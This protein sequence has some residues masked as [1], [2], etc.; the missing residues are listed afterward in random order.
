MADEQ[1]AI[2]TIL[3]APK[4]SRIRAARLLL[5]AI[6]LAPELV[7]L[8]VPAS[9]Q[10][11]ERAAAGGPAAPAEAATPKPAARREPGRVSLTASE[12]ESDS[13]G[14]TE[15]PE[16]EPASGSAGRATASTTF[17]GDLLRAPAAREASSPSS[18]R[19]GGSAAARRRGGT[20]R[21]PAGGRREHT[22]R[23]SYDDR[24]IDYR[25]SRARAESGAEQQRLDARPRPRGSRG[26]GL[27]KSRSQQWREQAGHFGGKGK[28]RYRR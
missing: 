3:R 20:S 1:H 10:V 17:G 16:R 11:Q 4:A 9:E 5:A 27:D 26:R 12:D 19:D 21:R 2:E 22:R 8:N 14:G 7:P 24:D 13:P 25:K 15:A 23:D 28:G 6:G 18:G